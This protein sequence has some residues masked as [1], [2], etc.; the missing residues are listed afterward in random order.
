ME[1]EQ[2]CSNL[3]STKLLES[4]ELM[5]PYVLQRDQNTCLNRVM[6]HKGL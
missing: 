3:V 6:V 2:E 1:S 5:A 4:L